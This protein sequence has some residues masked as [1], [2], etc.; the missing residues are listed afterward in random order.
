MDNMSLVDTTTSLEREP[1]VGKDDKAPDAATQRRFQRFDGLVRPTKRKP[2][3]A[4]RG[5][6][7][8]LSY[9]W[10]ALALVLLPFAVARWS[11]PLAAWLYPVFLLRFVRTQPLLRGILFAL[12]A[13]TLVFV[14]ALQGVFPIPAPLY[15]IAVFFMAV[16]FV[17][18]YLIDRV[19]AR[20]VGGMPGTLVFPSAVTTVWYLWALL[21]PAEAGT[22]VNPAYTQYGD[23]PLLQLLSVTGVWA[24]V[25]L[26]SWL[27]SV[28][29]WAWEREFAWPQVRGGA[30]LYAGLLAAV[31][32]FG[33]TRLAVFPPQ[34]STVR[35]AG[36]SPSRALPP[37]ETLAQSAFATQ[38]D[39]EH[40]R[41]TFAQ[42]MAPV[43]DDLFARS[44]QEA[45]AGAKIVVWSEGRAAVFEEDQAALFA[46]ASALTR[47]TGIYLNLA[48]TVLLQQPVQSPLRTILDQVALVD[49]S[50]NTVW[51]YEK[52]HPVPGPELAVT[53]PGD[54][55][56][57]TLQ[58][59]YGRLSSAICYDLDFLDIISNTGHASADLLLVPGGDWQGI[60]PLHAQMATFRAIENG[61]SLVR[62]AN[63]GLGIAV[64]YQGQVL[65]ASDYF[66]TDQQVI[67][68]Y[69]PTQGVHTLY[70][71]IGDLFAWLCVG[72]LV[73]LI[74][75]ALGRKWRT[76]GTSAADPTRGPL[77]SHS[78][79][80]G[81]TS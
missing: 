73:L 66:S 32:L 5:I 18:P 62:P 29:N 77:G 12:V 64:D 2:P 36:I 51:R 56:V 80:P 78:A 59:P 48:M 7:D 81:T 11:I 27:A 13:T 68:A 3:P 8:Q 30:L 65:A 23:L 10:L 35:V 19:I 41:Q 49:P 61:F 55:A 1:I 24:I 52:T 37:W 47:S 33:G 46:R 42:A 38:P 34:G 25:F 72:G 63:D 79:R 20:G 70:S 40:A 57:P 6:S 53:V 14:F 31:V 58:T 69:V 44:E 28:V 9:V 16:N 75:L 17:V 21:N 15:Y 45:R 60:D 50:G 71:T 26:M 22:W 76:I 39:R 74:G 54:G 67:V 4:V 43:Y